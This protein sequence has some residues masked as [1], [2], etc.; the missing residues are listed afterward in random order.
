MIQYSH[1]TEA[2]QAAFIVFMALD[3]GNTALYTAMPDSY[4][5]LPNTWY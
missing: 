2:A 5:V 4:R 3:A 1:P